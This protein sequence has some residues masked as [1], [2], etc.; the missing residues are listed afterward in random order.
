MKKFVVVLLAVLF[1]M[2]LAVNSGAAET[3]KGKSQGIHDSMYKHEDGACGYE[4]ANILLWKCS[5]NLD[6]M[7]NRRKPY[8]K[9]ISGPGRPR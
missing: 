3:E 9:F 4:T 5:K 6:L 2:G 8:V 7:I 1:F